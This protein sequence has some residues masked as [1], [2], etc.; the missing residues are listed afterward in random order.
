MQ[1]ILQYMGLTYSNLH[2]MSDSDALIRKNLYRENTAVF[3][4]YILGGILMSDLYEFLNFCASNNP[5]FILFYNIRKNREGLANLIK[6]TMLDTTL[7]AT[8]HCI[9]KDKSVCKSK[10]KNK[11][12]ITTMRMSLIDQICY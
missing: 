6:K 5:R 3:G 8:L 1:K 9:Y 12:L 2:G 7:L 4:Y 10:H 11:Y